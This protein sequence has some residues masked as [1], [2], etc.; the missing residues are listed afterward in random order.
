MRAAK[1]AGCSATVLSP[2]VNSCDASSGADRVE[3]ISLD[4][5]DQ[6][7]E[8]VARLHAEVPVAGVV[9]Y[10]EDAAVLAARV[11][12]SLGL[13][14]HPVHAAEA[15][16]D[17]PTM[18]RRFAAAGIP[19]AE[20]TV[21]RDED[22]AVQWAERIGYPVVVK[23][24]Q[25]ANSQGVIRADDEWQLRQAYRTLRR[26]VRDYDLHNGTR[27]NS[28]QL[29][30]RYLDGGEISVELLLQ[31]GRADVAAV[32]EKPNP[33]TGP[34]F[35]ETVYLTPPRM[36][37]ALRREAEELAIRAAAALGM[38]HGPAHCEIRLTSQGPVVLEIAARLL[39]GGCSAVL[40]DWLDG[41][42]QALLMRLAIGE[43]VVVPLARHDVPVAAAMMLPVPGEGRVAA[44]HGAARAM[45]VPWVRSVDIFACPGDVVVLPP[46]PMCYSVG[47]VLAAGP[48]HQAI[49]DSLAWA[50]ASIALDLA[51]M[52]RDR[53][54]R[55]VAD[56]D[57]GYRPSP[58]FAVHPLGELVATDARDAVVPI[59]AE[60]GFGE[61]PEQDAMRSASL[62]VAAA[63]EAGHESA[64]VVVADGGRRAMSLGFVDG[65]IGYL[66]LFAAPPDYWQLELPEVALR[67]QLA[68][69]ARRGCTHAVAE[70][71][72]RPQLAT[73]ALR[74]VGFVLDGS[75]NGS[76]NGSTASAADA[77]CMTC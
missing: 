65:R 63:E 76:T 73:T 28:V 3:R 5:P 10:E 21:A 71:D 56:D 70:L 53:W 48:S 15:A 7:V 50:S 57:A 32:F 58:A 24:C 8:L 35:E 74:R 43:P 23:P 54:T 72:P 16:L 29:V 64:W 49:E 42:F 9:S 38:W 4:D 44:V 77:A 47:T 13:P 30:E 2:N 19:I 1:R 33:L 62:A 17:K 34:F 68:E 18:K 66:R 52:G 40:Q 51:P 75:T 67:A 45:R 59:L 11:A 6:A 25:G 60:C 39:G 26:I 46:E 36:D 41:D 55:T 31:H 69:F 20:H 27:P 22:D 12:A 37:P 61:L 14:A